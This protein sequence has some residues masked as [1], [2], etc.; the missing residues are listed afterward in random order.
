MPSP[1]SFPSDLKRLLAAELPAA[2]LLDAQVIGEGWNATAWRLPDPSGDWTIRVPRLDDALPEM[3]GQTCLGPRLN[4]LG[5]PVPEGWRLLRRHD[6][7][8]AAGLYRYVDGAPSNARGLRQRRALARQIASFLSKLHALAPAIGRECGAQEVRPWQD[9]FGPMVDRHASTL[10]PRSEAWIRGVAAEVEAA[11]AD[12][13]PMR[14]THADLQPAHLIVDEAGVI[15]AVLDFEGP[16]VTDPA[17]DFSRLL[18]FW[19]A[20]FVRMVLRDYRGEVNDDFLVRAR[21]YNDL[22]LIHTM[23]TAVTRDSQEWRHW[24]PWARRQIA[25]RAGGATRVARVG[26]AIR[27][28]GDQTPAL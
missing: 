11:S 16:C 15:Q 24:A 10:S 13:H 28:S 26:A 6:G 23:H 5:F 18:Q 3:E 12:G 19:G 7:S 17:M 21:G 8:V 2:R 14:L 22:E 4:A 25:T 9:H 1:P 20:G 27:R